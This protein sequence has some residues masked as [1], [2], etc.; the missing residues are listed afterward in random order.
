MNSTYSQGKSSRID[1]AVGEAVSVQV[2]YGTLV[3]CLHGHV[4]LTQEGD[5]RDHFFAAGLTFCI[6]KPGRAVITAL[7]GPGVVIITRRACGMTAAY[8]P[9][10][11]TIDSLERLTA[12]ARQAQS[13]HMRR[14]LA[15]ALRWPLEALRRLQR[16]GRTAWKCTRS[17]LTP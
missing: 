8:I 1:I 9:G 15:W 17:G 16:A 6:D 3:Q 5:A 12:A 10:T 4:W 2:S 14:G 7:D 13:E 11:L